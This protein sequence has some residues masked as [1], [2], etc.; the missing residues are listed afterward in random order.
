[1]NS[2]ALHAYGWEE[3]TEP[4]GKVIEQIEVYV[5]DVFDHRDPV[6]KFVNLLHAKTR[7]WVIEQEVLQSVGDALDP[8]R[9]LET[10]RNLRGIRQLSLANVIVARG[11]QPGKVR[12]LVVAKD[13]WS[14]RLNANFGIGS[15]GLDY[16]LLN[17]A[18]ENLA[19]MHM[20]AGVLYQLERDR[21]SFGLRYVYPRLA[22]SRFSMA[23][24]SSFSTNNDTGAVEGTAGTFIFTLPLYSRHRR[25]A[26]GSEAAWNFQVVRRYQGAEIAT[27]DYEL[28]SG[29][30]ESVPQIF[31]SERLA[32]EYWALRSFGVRYKYDLSFG[33][34]IDSRTYRPQDLSMYAPE[35]QAAF[36]QAVL[37]VSDRRFSPYVQLRT[38]R[39]DFVRLID[40][41]LLGV[42]EDIRVGHEALT[43]IY[44]ASEAL[45]SSRSLIGGIAGV[46]YTW[47]LGTGLLRAVAYSDIVAATKDQH[48][49]Y[50]AAQG[51]LATPMLGPGRLHID[52]FVATRYL[53][54]LNVGP[55]ALGGN[56]RLRGYPAS[57]F[58]GRDLLAIN[59][60]FRT[61]SIDILSAQ[62]GLAAFLD[63][64]DVAPTLEA[65][66]LWGGAGLGLRILFP[67]ATRAV[68]RVDWGSPITVRCD[69]TTERCYG[70]WPG[71]VFATFGQAFSL[72]AIG[73]PRAISGLSQF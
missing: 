31:H 9:I 70:A 21:Q 17:P 57:E 24:E 41:E 32:A 51:R 20:T 25:F 72:P 53:N 36:E 6:P 43:R 40:F 50:F 46:G 68:L 47:A 69:P 58:R 67:Q 15:S 12:L 35:T 45:G 63:L 60:E 48:E 38:Y 26:Y 37:P 3:D 1:V 33:L 8:G 4:E 19:G 62:V 23:A 18:E 39:T 22:G 30:E 49:G 34:E 29:V 52:A 56:N 5:L 27:F 65:V 14:L 7:K 28:P 66:D 59:T 16:L 2:E 42:Q 61:H 13:V 54:Y 71:A 73:T 55:F 11:S 64:A 10:E 44:S